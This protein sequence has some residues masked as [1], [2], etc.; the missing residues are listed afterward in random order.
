MKNNIEKKKKSVRKASSA[1]KTSV[2][3]KKS[4]TEKASSAG[5]TNKRGKNG[6][7][8][9]TGRKLK[10]PVK[11]CLISAAAIALM[12][13]IA[14]I[15]FVNDKLNRLDYSD[16]T[17]TEEELS[18]T[19]S[20]VALEE[21]GLSSEEP[22]VIISAEEEGL[23]EEDAVL[24]EMEIFKD[25]DVLNI[26]LLGTDERRS[27]YSTNAR[28][29]SIMILS[30]N[31]KEG[32][33]KLASLERGM[34]FPILEG[35]YAGQYDWLTHCF[36]YGG[37]DLMLKEVR[38]CLRVDVDR[39]IRVNFNT[40]DQIIDAVGGVDIELTALEAQ[41]LN[42]EVRT[43]A[44]AKHTMYPGVNHLDGY[45]A[46]QY[47]RLR[48][49]DSDWKRVQRQRN[50]I[51][52]V[53]HQSKELNLIELNEATNTILPLIQTNMSK[54]E[55]LELTTYLPTLAGADIEQM[56]VPAKGTYGV[57]TGMG[58][59]TLYAVD[60][61]ENAAILKDFLYSTEE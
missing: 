20:E 18:A 5:V 14:G 31:R 53:V 13:I 29:D 39:Y 38:E 27:E 56:T 11:V 6:R 17:L 48:Y 52:A 15:W 51:Q 2:A 10:T 57:M 36:R 50:V 44:Y 33:M 60:F 23:E 47:A 21:L 37:A 25:D 12:I 26:L 1:G 8:R 9:R 45:D 42:G 7:K 59:R 28:A 34:G 58:G 55:V 35:A 49:I 24:T 3:G 40:F 41:G 30:L 46:L 19:A 4:A 43:N 54:T 16:G 32:T 61:E 22:E